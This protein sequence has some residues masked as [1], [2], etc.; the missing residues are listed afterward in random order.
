[1][2]A[3]WAPHAGCWMA[4]PCREALWGEGLAAA[5]QAYASVARAVARFEPVTMIVDSVLAADQCGGSVSVVEM[6]QD[7]SWTRDT[8]PTFVVDDAGRVAGVDWRFNGWGEV[9]PEHAKDAAMAATVLD[10]LDMRRYEAPFV[11]EGG[12]V[13]VD[14]AGTALAT[15]QC[16]LDPARNPGRSRAEV[17]ALLGDYLGST[18]VVW[19]DEGLAD[20]ETAGHIDNVACFARPG[21]VLLLAASDPSLANHAPLA[22]AFERLRSAQ[23]ARGAPLEVVRVEQPRER[24]GPDGLLSL[25]YINF[26]LANGAVI[27]PAFDDPADE[28]ARA[29]VAAAFPEREVVQLPA[30]PIVHGGGGIHCITQQQPAGASLR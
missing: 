20:D 3:E 11:L 8:G 12:A 26:Y 17:E 30:L 22:A 10:H 18:H 9:Y 14:G 19:L 29:A 24:S 15:E 16:L 27:M 23:D 13:H 7:D 28:P 2:P 4:W 1:M 21:V 25:S 6:A 5:R